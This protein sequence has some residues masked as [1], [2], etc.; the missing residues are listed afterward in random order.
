MN[1]LATPPF[2]TF[3]ELLGK[4]EAAELLAGTLQEEKGG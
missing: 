3:L 2:T 4:D 1:W